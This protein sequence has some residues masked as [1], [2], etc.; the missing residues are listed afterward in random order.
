MYDHMVRVLPAACCGICVALRR[1]ALSSAK[2]TYLLALYIADTA[3]ATNSDDALF[4]AV[5]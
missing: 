2:Q 4:A 1:A 5:V 3:R